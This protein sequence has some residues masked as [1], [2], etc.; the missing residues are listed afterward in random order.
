M[1]KDLNGPA[2]PIVQMAIW[3][4]HVFPPIWNFTAIGIQESMRKIAEKIHIFVTNEAKS[5]GKKPC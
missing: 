2:H 3:A 5:Q 4:C 1:F